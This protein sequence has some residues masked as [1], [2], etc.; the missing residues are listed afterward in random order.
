[1]YTIWLPSIPSSLS[2]RDQLLRG[3]VWSC[4]ILATLSLVFIVLF[5]VV[6][7]VP[8]LRV[9]GITRFVFDPSWHPQE[10][11]YTLLPMVVGTFLSTIGAVLIAWP[12][13]VC[14]ALFSHWYAPPLIGTMYS[15]F[16][17]LLAGI[18]SVVFGFWG[19]VVLVPIIN[20]WQPPGTSLLAGIVILALMIVPTMS[21]LAQASFAQVPQE[22]IQGAAALG[23]S[24]WAMLRRVVIPAAGSGLWTAT[25]L[26][27]AR[28][29]GETMAVLMVCGNVVQVP[30]SVFDPIRTMTA[31][32][33]LEM[34]YAV[35]IHR[36]ALF[37]CGLILLL[38]VSGLVAVATLTHRT[39]HHA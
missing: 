13:G 14:S 19:L 22:Y 36:S 4:A 8:A 9:L 17:E 5:L 21:V 31:N 35:G 24:R 2:L 12:C 16:I 32:I 28:A 11:S 26:S 34:A 39:S 38:V 37:V 29:L 30:S 23:M 25:W 27:T 6:E 10:N 18:P 3:I 20:R 15:R 1:M 33:A 7:S